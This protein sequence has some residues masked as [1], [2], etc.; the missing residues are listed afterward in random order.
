MERKRKE[1]SPKFIGKNWVKILF[2]AH[3]R[4]SLIQVNEPYLTM[5]YQLRNDIYT[6]FE[7]NAIYYG[8]TD[9][10]YPSFQKHYGFRTILSAADMVHSLSALIESPPEIAHNVGNKLSLNGF[11][12]AER[13]AYEEQDLYGTKSGFFLAFDALDKYSFYSL[14]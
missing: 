7:K 12:V 9:L 4:F 11:S 6:K 13:A 10:T 5:D 14:I 1:I 3:S 2:F 8:L